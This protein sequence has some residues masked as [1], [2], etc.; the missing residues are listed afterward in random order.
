MSFAH[1]LLQ[2]NL[3]LIVFYGFY[4]LLL[5][6]ETYFT[7]NRIYLVSGGS[8]S[9]VIPFIRLEW[10]TEQKA[11][12]HI[13]TSVN[14]DS[15]L[16]QATIATGDSIGFNWG[17]A[18]VHVYCSGSVFFLARL[19][20]NLFKVKNLL[21]SAKAGSAFS[22][23]SKKIV[24]RSLPQREVIDL[25]EEI[26]VKQWHT[27]DILFFEVLAILTWFNPIIYFY[28]K[29]IKN[30]HEFLADEEAAAFQ[31]DK[32]AYAMLILSQSFGISPHSLTNGFFNKSLIKKRIFMLQKE[33]S[34]KVAIIKYGISIPLFAILLIFSSATLRKNEKLIS[35]TDQIP[36]NKPIDAV[37]EMIT[38]DTMEVLPE[39]INKI[40][41]SKEKM[42]K[43]WAKFYRFVSKAIN[44]PVSARKNNDQGNIQIRFSIRNSKTL[45]IIANTA[46]GTDCK[47]EVIEAVKAYKNFENI[48]DGNYCFTVSFRLPGGSSPFISQNIKTNP[49]Y[50]KLSDITIMAYS[51]DNIQDEENIK[52]YDFTSIDKVPEFP[53]GM[54]KFDE[55]LSKNIKY[56]AE[57]I[58]NNVQGKVFL[59]FNVEKNGSLTDIQITRGLGSGTDEEA[60][61]VIK[62][63]PNWKPGIAEGKAV[64]VKYNIN[65][66]FNLSPFSEG[67]LTPAAGKKSEKLNIQLRRKNDITDPKDNQFDG[68]VVIDGVKMD[69]PNI[70][71]TINSEEIESISI[72]KGQSATALYGERGIQ[73][74][75]IITT[76][77]TAKNSVKKLN[78]KELMIEQ[79]IPYYNLR[80]KF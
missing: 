24:D 40:M 23:L 52:T 63:S 41:P 4:K 46:L 25:H 34:K 69:S 65:V 70:L 22:F 10:L 66:N 33:R 1:Y 78:S 64:R 3:Y 11:A 13:Y 80:Q 15:V 2:V 60:I 49:S 45:N 28:K 76:K 50:Q 29:S 68:I 54:S 57:A 6:K 27:L 73:G 55:F 47:Q 32:A 30:I 37:T 44:Y 79:S 19:M 36:M 56:P 61:R 71:N 20:L 39:S 18:L 17:N 21:V 77:V 26:H 31:G 53:G 72:L 74:V 43:N 67:N 12:Q 51:Q 14:W 59:S 42:D 38:P 7:L 62:S 35:I 8:L 58:K 16:Q 9:L 75:V 5:D 48:P